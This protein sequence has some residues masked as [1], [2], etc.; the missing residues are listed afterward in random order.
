MTGPATGPAGRAR[1]RS[2]TGSCWPTGCAGRS[3]RAAA[4]PT[5]SPAR[6]T[7][8]TS[9]RSPRCRVRTSTATRSNGRPSCAVPT[10]AGGSTSAAR[11]GTRTGGSTRIDADAPGSRRP[12][13][14]RRGRRRGDRLQGPGRRRRRPRAGR[15]GSAATRR[16]RRGRGPDAHRV[17]HE[18][19]RPG[20]GPSDGTALAPRPGTWDRARRPHH[21]GPARR[22]APWPLRRPCDRRAELV[23]A[24]RRRHGPSFERFD[25]ADASAGLSPL[26]TGALR[27]ATWSRSPTAA[28]GYTSRPAGPT[29]RTTSA[30][31]RPADAVAEPVVVGL[32]GERAEQRDVVGEVVDQL[33]RCSGVSPGGWRAGAGAPTA[34]GATPCARR[35]VA[36]TARRRAGPKRRAQQRVARV[37]GTN[38]T[39]CRAERGRSRPSRR[40]GTRRPGRACRA[41]WSTRS[42]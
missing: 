13:A 24:D 8:C 27:Y 22:T 1:C 26:G 11:P 40:R 5:W 9:R 35:A 16:R 42:R 23:R 21:R 32:S 41:G 30:P 34:A 19:R 31:S 18:R 29:A 36:R 10:A 38:A 3:T 7:A 2:T 15:C 4:S 37:S 25:A 33:G 12:P 39:R 6:P 17:R 14:H 28:T 20:R